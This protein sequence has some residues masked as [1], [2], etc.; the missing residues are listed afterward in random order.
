[1]EFWRKNDKNSANTR[2]R[3]SKVA[4]DGVLGVKQFASV[5]G[6]YKKYSLKSC[7]KQVF[8][9]VK[10]FAGVIGI[11]ARPTPVA[12]AMKIWEFWR[13]NG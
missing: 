1:M 10:Q 3:A 4:P 6:I 5:I 13:K 9:G 7:T 2:N 11:Y 8:L 12:M